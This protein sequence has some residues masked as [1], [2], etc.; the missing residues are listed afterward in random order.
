[1]EASAFELIFLGL[2][3]L[4]AGWINTVAGAGSLLLLPALMF[5]GLDANAANATNRLGI[6]TTAFAALIGYRRA[7]LSIGKHEL[8]LTVAAMFG[9]VLGAFI[10]TLLS[11]AKMQFAI[12]LAMGVMLVLSF[13]PARRRS[14]RSHEKTEDGSRALDPAHTLPSPTPTMI[15]CFIGIG[16]YGGFL[17]AGL[18][19][20]VL[21]YL[22]IAHGV[23]L[24]HSNVAKSTVT[25]SLCIVAILVFGA[26][27]ETID[28]A[29]GGVLAVSSA[30]GGL[31]GARSATRFGEPLI[32]GVVVI[33]VMASMAKLIVDLTR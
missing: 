27:G 11:P 17:Q 2:V 6:L 5:T 12:V 28:L 14:H 8:I 29:R 19:I 30:M 15:L 32:R 7:G 25:F 26:R 21:L 18:G 16:I 9:G 3:G 13:I 1:M 31:L 33:A 23:S 4:V 22:S 24:I 20:V 10:A